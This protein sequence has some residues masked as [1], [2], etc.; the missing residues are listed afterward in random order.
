M[1]TT[2]NLKGEVLGGP[3]N[4]PKP[5]EEQQDKAARGLKE[6][7]AAQLAFLAS[8]KTEED[9]A[10]LNEAFAQYKTLLTLYHSQIYGGRRRKTR[11]GGGLRLFTRR[12]NPPKRYHLSH[13]GY[14][15]GPPPA[16]AGDSRRRLP[17]KWY[18]YKTR[19]GKSRRRSTR[20]AARASRTRPTR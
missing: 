3:K 9:K 18:T 10:K 14:A 11:G 20:R 17:E 1:S 7:R 15:N 16:L 12:H 13:I 5:T 6:Y 8:K 4:P 19:G 2:S